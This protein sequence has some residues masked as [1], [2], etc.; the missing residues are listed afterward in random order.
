MLYGLWNIG[1]HCTICLLESFTENVNK[2]PSECFFTFSHNLEYVKVHICQ[3]FEGND[4]NAF[5]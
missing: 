2:V 3:W 5:L 1:P 4:G